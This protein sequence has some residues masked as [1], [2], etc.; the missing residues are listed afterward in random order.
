M[1]FSTQLITRYTF[2]FFLLSKCWFGLK[3]LIKGQYLWTSSLAK[4]FWSAP[5]EPCPW[6]RNGADQ[7]PLASE[8]D[9]WKKKIPNRG[10]NKDTD[11]CME[12]HNVL[13]CV[14]YN[15]SEDDRMKIKLQVNVIENRVFAEIRMLF[16]IPILRSFWF[17]CSARRLV[18][19]RATRV[20]N[21]IS[22]VFFFIFRFNC[23]FF[24]KY[25]R[26]WKF[27]S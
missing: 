20:S 22:L 5:H 14:C 21:N 10:L 9:L 26:H 12:S 4:G 24:R 7:E 25:E 19:Q 1:L 6:S 27:L 13:T 15:C 23:F 2:W 18:V 17:I 3:A 11:G 8:D 16:R